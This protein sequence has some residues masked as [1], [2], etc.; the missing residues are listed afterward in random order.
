M[1]V[2]QQ[3]KKHR[4]KFIFTT[5]LPQPTTPPNSSNSESKL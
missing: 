3:P 5:D 2:I 4:A 1:S